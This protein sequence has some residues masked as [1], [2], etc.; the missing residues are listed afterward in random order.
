MADS[1]FVGVDV[2]P[3]GWVSVGLDSTGKKVEL[4]PFLWFKNLLDYYK[5]AKLI[6]VDIPIGLPDTK[7]ERCCDTEAR[8]LLGP[9]WSSVFRVPTRGAVEHFRQKNGDKEGASKV[10]LE[11]TEEPIKR[12]SLDLLPK[13]VQVD[14]LLPHKTLKVREVHPEVCFRAFK[15]RPLPHRSKRKPQGVEE[16]I[17]ILNAVWPDT[18]KIIQASYRMVFFRHFDSD[19]L[20]DALAAAVTAYRG[21]DQLQTLPTNPPQDSNGLPMEIVYWEPPVE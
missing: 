9:R 20:L 6:L 1:E 21:Y 17:R 14:N 7:E 2:C 19:D 8:K 4:K 13:I 3:S 5:S 15:G 16:R 18:D 11:I 12:R 10:Q